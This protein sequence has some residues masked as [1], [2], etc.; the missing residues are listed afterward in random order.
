MIVEKGTL[1]MLQ[2]VSHAFYSHGK[3]FSILRCF[4]SCCDFRAGNPHIEHGLPEF[5]LISTH[6]KDTLGFHLPVRRQTYVQ[7]LLR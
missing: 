7:V 3:I 6:N 1:E 2:N 5:L 4:A